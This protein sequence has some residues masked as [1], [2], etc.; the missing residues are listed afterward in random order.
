MKAL[1]RFLGV[2]LLLSSVSVAFA[3]TAISRFTAATALDVTDYAGPEGGAGYTDGIGAS[4]RFSAPAGIWGD[5]T[6]VYIADSVN[7]V[8]RRVKIS[9]GL[10]DTIAG[11]AGQLGSR[12][13][14]GA[15]ARFVLPMGI[16]GEGDTL[17]VT[18]AGTFTVRRVNLSTGAV[19]TIA[20]TPNDPGTTDGTFARFVGPTGIWGDGTSLYVADSFSASTRSI[21]QITLAT[22]NVSTIADLGAPVASTLSFLSGLPLYGVGLWGDG[23]HLYIADS[24]RHTIRRLVLATGQISVLTGNDNRAGFQD[25]TFSGAQFNSPSAIWGTGS[26][27]YVADTGNFTIRALSLQAGNVTTVAGTA[28]SA[29]WA[30]GV[31][32]QV[33]FG[34]ATGMWGSSTALYITDFTNN[35][36]RR[37][38]ITAANS[39]DTSTL[40]GVP[41][42]P[43]FT[44]GS[45]IGAR[46]FNPWG[47]WADA[48]NI[49]VSDYVNSTVRRIAIES[50]QVSTLA[51]SAL[52]F[53]HRDGQGQAVRFGLP[54]GIW[55]D[56]TNLYVTDSF[57]DTI[58]KIVIATGVVTTIAGDPSLPSGSNDGIGIQATFR[59]PMA[60][61][62]NSTDLYVADSQNYTIRKIVIATGA[63]SRFA[64]V[65][66]TRGTEDSAGGRFYL[67]Q[68]LWGDATNLYVAD[69]HAIRKIVLATHAV[70]TLAGSAASPG[71]AD[72]RTALFR[73]PTGL[74]GDGTSLFVADTGNHV[75]RKI[76]LTTGVVSTVAGNFPI[77][78]SE[79]GRGSE[80]RFASPMGLGGAGSALYVADSANN[81]IRKATPVD[82]VPVT[83]NP[84]DI[85][86]RIV[87]SGGLSRATTGSE[88]AVR[89]GYARLLPDSGNSTPAGIAIFGFTQNGVLVSEAAV[90]ASPLVQSGR[91][92]AEIAGPVNTGLAISNPNSTAATVS[93]YFTDANGSNINSGSVVIPPNGQIAKFLNESPFVSSTTTQ[94]SLA[95]VRSFTFTSTLAVSV[96]A[97]R[98]FTNEQSEF[99]ITTLPVVDLDSTTSSPLSFPHYADGAGWKTD[100]IL[101]NPT[102]STLTGT[103]QFFSQGDLSTA[104]SPTT[105]VVNGASGSSFDYSIPP[106]SS[107]KFQ[108]SN[109]EDATRAGSV[110]VTPNG[111]TRA[112]S[113]LVVFSFRRLGKVVSEAGVQALGTASAFRLYAEASGDFN[114]SAPGSIQTGFAISN[115]SSSNV[116]VIFELTNLD[117][118]STGQVGSTTIP[119]NGQ[120]AMFIDQ[121]PGFNN[122]QVPFKGI[123]RIRGANVS[124]VGLRARYNEAGSFLITT[125]P[126]IDESAV[127]NTA[128]LV[129]PHFVDGGG[130]TTQFILFGASPNQTPGGALRFYTQSGQGLNV[131]LR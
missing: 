43:G 103:I 74:W 95:D 27:L 61:W 40:S 8:I 107:V 68:A 123:L 65:T 46:F 48:N 88:S 118:V 82:P 62:G 37:V 3:Q 129:F 78:G 99:L 117:G 10:V 57:F 72:G 124:V 41:A 120:V 113:G 21:R 100:V 69:G 51:G 15:E 34:A 38:S 16:W 110:R 125:T 4:V 44:D 49:Y 6:Y 63:V 31:R 55:G 79:N 71:Y 70:T 111:G 23:T 77:A 25:S 90:P 17:Y 42:R 84:A 64:G 52:F 66:G 67:P 7:S 53:N 54:T 102:E 30:D 83:N 86:Y 60:I 122:L 29:G 12:D 5:G 14:V 89:I 119:A 24:S 116:T 47:I 98:G 93:F 26:T 50:G 87:N 92:Y 96:V 39:G 36:I 58:R 106:R 19:T 75:I 11:T 76:D 18:D 126:P 109:P 59:T 121:I 127:P 105:L 20:G 128:Q 94:A 91:I 81:K 56:G 35:A 28:R 1:F 13:G 2:F 101:L 73:S 115:A 9:T 131:D 112:P 80:A 33:R 108:T 32:A 97:L 114:A 85:T 130:Y 104:G 22:G 45:R